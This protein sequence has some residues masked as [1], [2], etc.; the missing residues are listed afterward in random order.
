MRGKKKAIGVRASRPAKQK[1]RSRKTLID[2]I[3]KSATEEFQRY[4]FAGAATP[5]IARKAKVTET[6]LY[7]CFGSKSNLFRETI[8]KPLDQHFLN[9]IKQQNAGDENNSS[10][11]EHS[12]RYTTEL[13]QFLTEHS[14]MLMSLIVTQKYNAGSGYDLGSISSFNTFFEHCAVSMAE[15]V[16]S[17]PKVDVKL[18]VRVTFAAVLGCVM[19]KDW[20]FPAGL[21]SDEQIRAAI[22]DFVLQGISANYS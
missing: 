7:R 17:Q 22:N 21:A 11:S 2:S 19:F 14:D 16:K 1:R 12:K 3:V 4:G 9:Y 13:Q 18:M 8:F 20:I 10:I 15:R 5:E 6:Q